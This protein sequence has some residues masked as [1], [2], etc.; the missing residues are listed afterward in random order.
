MNTI[1]R[2]F[3]YTCI[4]AI[5][6]A[7]C[8]TTTLTVPGRSEEALNW[9]GAA[10]AQSIMESYP[11]SPCTVAQVDVWTAIQT[12]KVESSWDSD[13]QGIKTTMAV[14]CPA[15][16]IVFSRATQQELMY[17][18]AHYMKLYRYPVALLLATE[19]HNSFTAH[20]EHWVTV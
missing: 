20:Q 2:T 13:P 10:A 16:W 9:C 12:N 19:A 11:A 1:T 18:V 8:V 6:C 7:R 14:Q 15:S 17:S 5:F 3:L 4:V